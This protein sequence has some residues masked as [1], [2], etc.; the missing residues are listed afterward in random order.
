MPNNDPFIFI[1]NAEA[2]VAMEG[3]QITPQMR[4]QCRQVLDGKITTA[5]LLKQFS[6]QQIQN[7]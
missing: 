4:E 1:K 2:S 3:F 6:S 7:R 5:Q